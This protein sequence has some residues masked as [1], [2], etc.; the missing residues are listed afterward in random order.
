MAGCET[1][2]VV[3]RGICNLETLQCTCGWEFGES[4]CSKTFYE[5]L[6][7]AYLAYNLFGIVLSSL[8]FGFSGLVLE[9]SFEWKVVQL[10]KPQKFS[11]FILS[12]GSF[13]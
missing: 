13:G 11:L 7:N 12:L 6:G 8:V 2:C 3:G 5:V 9:K 10:E 4:D 1:T